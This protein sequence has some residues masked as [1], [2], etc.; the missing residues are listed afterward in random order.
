LCYGKLCLCV[1]CSGGV[2][3]RTK[4]KFGSMLGD[5]AFSVV[6]VKLPR[7]E[8]VNCPGSTFNEG[9]IPVGCTTLSGNLFIVSTSLTA[10]PTQLST[11]V[12]IQTHQQYR[13]TEK[14]HLHFTPPYPL[15]SYAQTLTHTLHAT[16][17]H[18]LQREYPTLLNTA[19]N[20][21]PQLC[22]STS[23]Y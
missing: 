2:V 19:P 4:M 6:I 5:M 11:V 8:A 1:V 16:Q 21:Q 22:S 10:L 12:S 3:A 15:S 23:F 9:N 13:N 7:A 14:R 17:Q 18:T 20:T